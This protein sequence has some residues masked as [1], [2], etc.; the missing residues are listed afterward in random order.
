[1]Y[2]LFAF[3]CLMYQNERMKSVAM[4]PAE[5]HPI[6]VE[7]GDHVTSFDYLMEKEALIVGTRN[8]LLLLFS[9]DG[10]GS[11]VVGRVEGGVKRIS[12]SP[13]GD[14]LCIISGLRQ[15]LVMTHDWDL[16][17]VNT[18]ED[19]PEGVLTYVRISSIHD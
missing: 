4:L 5:V 10:N 13:D 15:I 8:G 18:L 7:T 9:V 14:L 16:M 11:E 17:Y 1:M 19:F 12:P 6:D 2:V 3:L